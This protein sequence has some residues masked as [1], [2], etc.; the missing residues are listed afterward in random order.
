MG[1]SASGNTILCQGLLPT[2]FNTKCQYAT[3]DVVGRKIVVVD[4]PGWS[5][6][7][8]DFTLEQ[9]KE[10]VRGL[11]LC[12]PGPNAFLL[13]LPSDMAF[14]TQQQ[15]ALE[16]HMALFGEDIWKFTLVVFTYGD[17]LGDQTIDEHI[18]MESPA[19]QQLVERCGNRYHVLN[20]KSKSESSQVPALLEKIEEMVAL[21]EG[22]HYSPNMMEINQRVEEKF[23]KREISVCLERKWRE[24]EAEI[25]VCLEKKW[26]E[27]E[28]E[29][30][31]EFRD[32][33]S[34]LQADLRGPKGSGLH[35]PDM[36]LQPKPASKCLTLPS[37]HEMKQANVSACVQAVYH[38]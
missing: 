9:D 1:K 25:S 13:V 15:R 4:T 35:T 34:D 32:Y 7:Y 20:N 24:Q 17:Q 30:R 12:P 26:R 6:Y 11:T 5:K 31:K 27:R 29:M 23:T 18:M 10:I 16:E 37:D 38:T 21:N 3:A 22:Q 2:C 19:L 28:V 14:T 36:T 8:K 33:L